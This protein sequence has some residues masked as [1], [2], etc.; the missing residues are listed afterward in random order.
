MANGSRR[1][2]SNAEKKAAVLFAA[3]NT[4]NGRQQFEFYCR[5]VCVACFHQLA[6][7][8]AAG[9]K[10]VRAEQFPGPEVPHNDICWCVTCCGSAS[11]NVDF[12]RMYHYVS[13]AYNPLMPKHRG[14]H[15]LL[16]YGET[17]SHATWRSSSKICSIKQ[18]RIKVESQKNVFL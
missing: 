15:T 1:F 13:Q 12:S 14:R 8:A 16:D 17:K 10:Q 7:V 4:R 5:T 2:K 18:Y 11:S 9:E 3:L 6:Q